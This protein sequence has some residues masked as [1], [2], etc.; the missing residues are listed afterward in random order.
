MLL[1]HDCTTYRLL[2]ATYQIAWREGGFDIEAY[3]YGPRDKETFFV[4]GERIEKAF[5]KAVYRDAGVME[6]I[7]RRL[8][9]L[10]YLFGDDIANQLRI[11]FPEVSG[12]EELRNRYMVAWT[13]AAM[14]YTDEVFTRRAAET[15][16][17]W[18]NDGVAPPRIGSS[19]LV[20]KGRQDKGEGWYSKALD[21]LKGLGG[22]G[23]LD[24]FGEDLDTSAYALNSGRVT[25]LI[26]YHSSED[27]WK[28]RRA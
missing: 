10:F 20:G 13:G 21:V 2:T 6:E 9:A 18:L 15:L 22:T 11:A 16:A 4:R 19:L 1:A 12:Q 5:D 23:L 17:A 27:A 26:V 25:Y 8:F 24:E 7:E 28:V 3:P 14:T